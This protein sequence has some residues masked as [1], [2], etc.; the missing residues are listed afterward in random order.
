MKTLI[1]NFTEFHPVGATLIYAGRL[2][3]GWTWWR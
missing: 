3:D 2:A 1:S